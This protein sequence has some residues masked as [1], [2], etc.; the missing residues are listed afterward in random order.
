[1]QAVALPVAAT[2]LANG[3]K[4]RVGGLGAGWFEQGKA[5]KRG[6]ELLPAGRQQAHDRIRRGHR[7]RR[8]TGGEDADDHSEPL[9]GYGSA[10]QILWIGEAMEAVPNPRGICNEFVT[11]GFACGHDRP[12]TVI[13]TLSEAKGRD[14]AA[15]W[16][17]LGPARSLAALGMT[18]R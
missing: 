13:P 9:F 14:L 5:G 15:E 3:P 2:G 18:T 17:E 7:V 1:M 11:A 6:R 16:L 10:H 12:A 8:A 4:G